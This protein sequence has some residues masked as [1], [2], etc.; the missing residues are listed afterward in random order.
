MQLKLPEWALELVCCPVCKSSISF[1]D[2]IRCLNKECAAV[3][4]VVDGIP[5]L[6]DQKKSIFTADDLVTKKYTYVKPASQHLKEVAFKL[7]P[8]ISANIKAR[9]NY[10]RLLQLLLLDSE[11][12][13]V[14]VLGGGTLGKGIELLLNSSVELLETDVYFGPRTMAIVDAHCIPFQHNSFECVIIQAVLEH[15]L[16]PYACVKEIHRVLKHDGLVY[17]ETAFMQQMHGGN[18]DFTRFTHQGHRRLFAGFQEIESGA[19]CGTGM[20]LAWAYEYFLMSLTRSTTIRTILRLFARL[21]AFW[22]KYFDYLTI[23]NP[24]TIEGASAFYF[25]GRKSDQTIGDRELIQ[26]D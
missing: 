4:P 16:D 2:K 20:V 13:K 22:L 7:A 18:F 14:L 12:P 11:N 9:E 19:V 23:D 17:A 6:L 25:M 3:F 1:Q 8:K 10:R 5:I 26:S 24:G 21:T 15:V